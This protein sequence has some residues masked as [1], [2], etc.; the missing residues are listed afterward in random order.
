MLQRNRVETAYTIGLMSGTSMDGIDAIVMDVKAHRL[1]AAITVPY[2]KPTIKKLQHVLEQ[3]K[4]RIA[5]LFELNQFI[6]RDFAQ[7]VELLLEQSGIKKESV[8]AIG[9][10]GQT[11]CHDTSGATAYTLQLGC[12]HTIAQVT[13]IQVVSDFRTRDMVAG[14]QGAPLTPIYH[15]ERLAR[16]GVSIAVVNIGGIANVSLLH[17]AKQ[18][19]GWDTGPGNCLLD[20]WA[21]IH[22]DKPFDA[23]GQ[24]AASGQVIP[25]LLDRL[26][27]DEALRRKPPKSY[28]REYFSLKWLETFLSANYQPQDVQATLTALTAQCIIE[29]IALSPK[30]VTTLYICGGGA[31]NNQILKTLKLQLTEVCIKKTSEAG[32]SEDYMEAMCFAWLASKTIHYEAL[33]FR[34][35]TG[36]RSKIISG[37]IYP[38]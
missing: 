4:H 30:P 3:D 31:H 13:G 14:G 37:V 32:I 34:E 6:G 9:S 11:I 33:D 5:T 24:W 35:I 29:A 21:K 7:A 27:S 12:A 18:V 36:S 23:S 26:L 8:N 1:I 38:V 22:I 20:Q 28:G 25:E 17:D 10:H 16:P 19:S 2:S 15:L